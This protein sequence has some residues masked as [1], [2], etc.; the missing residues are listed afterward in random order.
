MSGKLGTRETGN[1]PVTTRR[2][3]SLAAGAFGQDT[4]ENIR[5]GEQLNRSVFTANEVWLGTHYGTGQQVQ[6]DGPRVSQEVDQKPTGVFAL[7]MTGA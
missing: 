7:L 3:D 5:S 6:N 1:R 2:H 4:P